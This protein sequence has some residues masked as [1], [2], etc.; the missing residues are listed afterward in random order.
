MKK[1]TFFLFAVVGL[2]ITPDITKSQSWERES[3]VFS[4]GMGVS[5][6]YHIDDYYDN[7]E[8]KN[9]HWYRPVTA[10]L[11]FQ[12]EFGIHKYIGLG[13]TTGA[14][15]KMGVSS[16]SF[17]NEFN[18]PVGM[19]ANFHFYQLIADKSTKNIHADKLDIYFGAN[20]GSGIAIYNYSDI[21][22]VV[23]MLF[24][25]AQLGIRYYL[26]PKFGLNG[27]FGIGKS[28]VNIGIVFKS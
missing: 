18:V 14:G 1:I 9:F 20:L 26:T 11:N 27:E 6:F 17:R 23:P 12:A 16:R 3:R 19:I 8:K 15:S 13:F 7:I 10:Q 22:R 4:I 24:G 2:V 21:T 5:Q 28:M 25:G